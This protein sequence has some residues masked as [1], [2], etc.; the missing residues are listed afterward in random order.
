MQMP[1]KRLAANRR[2]A[3][4]SIGPRTEAGKNVSM[5]NAITHGLCASQIV[6]EDAKEIRGRANDLFDALR[7][8]NDW[9]CWIVGKVSLLTFQIDRCERMDRRTRDKIAIKAELS[10]DDDKGL[11]ATMLGEQ[12]G[13][14][15]AVVVD[16][17]RRTP[18]GCEWLIGRWAMLAYWAD[19]NKD[20]WTSEQQQL[21]FD[22]MATP[23][24]FRVGIAPGIV[25][26]SEGRVTDEGTDLAAVARRQ[27]AKLKK[28]LEEVNGLDQANRA[29][30][31]ADLYDDHDP[32]LKGSASTKGRCTPGS[33]GACVNSSRA[34]RSGRPRAG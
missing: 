1:D 21:A 14:R 4:L 11:A 29:L 2:N 3:L 26:D 18:Q 12:L 10:W 28:R 17:L 5:A 8:Q 24:D 27:I 6:P 15:P 13:N 20:G 33:A 32:E 22:L 23:G 9:Q 25:I 19:H 31:M 7:P 34:P 16:Q 30:A